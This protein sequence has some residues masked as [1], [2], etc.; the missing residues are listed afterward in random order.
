MIVFVNNFLNELDL[1]EVKCETLKGIVDLFVVIESPVTFSGVNK[2]MYYQLNK[3]R[4]EKYPIHHVDL[5]DMPETYQ[6]FSSPWEREA[7]QNKRILDTLQHIA[8]EYVI[9]GDADETVKPEAVQEFIDKR[10]TTA[11]FETDMLLFYFNR[12][13]PNPWHYTRMAKFKGEQVPR[14][15]FRLPMIYDAGWHF[16]FFGERNTLLEKVNATSHAIE[17]GGRSFYQA[18]TRGER[19]GIESCSV[20]PEE[21]LPKFVIDNRKRFSSWFLV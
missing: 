12:M 19:P 21:K 10:Y 2:A 4:F 1:L 9:W 15:N 17:P 14:G 13:S 5:T 18:I 11:N 7:A 16:E 8:P 3:Q 20:Y 6:T